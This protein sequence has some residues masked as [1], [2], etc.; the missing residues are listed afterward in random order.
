MKAITN[1]PLENKRGDI[2]AQDR[3]QEK[4][5]VSQMRR[6]SQSYQKLLTI[7]ETIAIWDQYAGFVLCMLGDRRTTS[8]I[9]NIWNDHWTFNV[10]P[11]LCDVYKIQE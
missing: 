4:G 8:S 7:T 2:N 9:Y 11:H 5:E 1:S 10:A 3:W 6:P